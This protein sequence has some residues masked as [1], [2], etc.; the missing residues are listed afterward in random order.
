MR[1]RPAQRAW[2]TPSSSLPDFPSTWQQPA[3]PTP[4]L[5]VP[6]SPAAPPFSSVTLRDLPLPG[7]REK[8][9]CCCFS[10]VCKSWGQQRGLP[11]VSH[12][13]AEESHS[14]WPLLRCNEESK[15]GHPFTLFE[16][17]CS[18]RHGRESKGFDSVEYTAQ[19]NTKKFSR[20]DNPV[21]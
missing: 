10:V 2:I 7:S 21:N 13:K 16:Q 1:P 18:F 3:L 4:S 19:L 12:L 6:S 9:S 17:D 20:E 11:L 5:W 8:Q 14:S 15:P